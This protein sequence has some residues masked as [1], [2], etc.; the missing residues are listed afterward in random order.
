MRFLSFLLL[1]SFFNFFSF[2]QEVK[3]LDEINLQPID[4]VIVYSE[5]YSVV[6]NTNGLADIS[7]ISAKN[8]NEK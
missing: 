1:L 4:N 6:T 8:F 7:K 3:V 2:S 5:T